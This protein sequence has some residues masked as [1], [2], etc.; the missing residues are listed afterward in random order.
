VA[1]AISTFLGKE[2]DESANPTKTVKLGQTLEEVVA[3]LGKPEK[4]IE[5]GEKAIYFYKDMKITFR[6]GKVADVE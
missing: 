1:K 6:D 5:L 2:G 3:I 4:T